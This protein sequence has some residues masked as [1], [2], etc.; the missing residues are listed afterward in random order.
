M[1]KLII[2]A[3][4]TSD[5]GIGPG[6]DW[7]DGGEQEEA[8]DDELRLADAMLLGR[9]TYE[10]LSETWQN[11]DGSYAERVNAMP[12]FVASTTLSAPLGWN[13]TLIE[14]DLEKEVRR[15]K[16][17]H[18]GNLLSYGCGKFAVELVKH[19]LADEI[20][21]W[22]HPVIWPSD[23]ERPFLGLAKV[24]METKDVRV[25]RNGVVLHSYEPKS[26]E[27]L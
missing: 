20:R 2:T 26:L 6:L 13:A 1:G 22:V 4:M 15:L 23:D 17:E 14:G 27:E 16:E 25:F 3:Q 7:F 24:R 18:E 11:T 8:G 19:G 12:K 9:K 10:V 21:F 5:A